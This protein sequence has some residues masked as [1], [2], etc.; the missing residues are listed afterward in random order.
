MRQSCWTTSFLLAV[1]GVLITFAGA[2]ANEYAVG[3]QAVDSWRAWKE[4]H[5]LPLSKN[6]RA[7]EKLL[8]ELF[9]LHS[10][11]EVYGMLVERDVRREYLRLAALMDKR[12]HWER[13]AA[14]AFCQEAVAREGDRDPADFVLRTTRA[15][16]V[17]LSRHNDVM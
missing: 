9:A 7:E 6:D 16:L 11:A 1:A 15:L 12:D 13:V 10:Y 5:P 17:D 14:T 3:K 8:S 4:M 2:K